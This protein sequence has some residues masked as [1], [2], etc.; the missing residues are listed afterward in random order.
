MIELQG[1]VANA[2]RSVPGGGEGDDWDPCET[3]TRSPNTQNQGPEE[4]LGEEKQMQN[5]SGR[6]IIAL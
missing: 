2:G 6:W 5:S 1:S 4:G 3:S